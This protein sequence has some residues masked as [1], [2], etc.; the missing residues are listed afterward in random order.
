MRCSLVSTWAL[1]VYP[2]DIPSPILKTRYICLVLA[3]HVPSEVPRPLSMALTSL[4]AIQEIH[5]YTHQ[6]R[7]L[8][9]TCSNSL[10]N[11]VD[12]FQP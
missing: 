4:L 11:C 10:D 3:S 6:C 12:L 5:L 8:Y 1:Y 2:C 7:A 9:T